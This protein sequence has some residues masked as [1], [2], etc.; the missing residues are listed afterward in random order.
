MRSAEL[1]TA[2]FARFLA[3]ITF[4][5]RPERLRYLYQV[6]RALA[7]FLVARMDV[8]VV[9]NT[10]AQEEVATLERML[11]TFLPDST[12]RV[13]SF[14]LADP[15]E[16]PWCHKQVLR[17]HFLGRGRAYTHFLY[18]EDDILF[19]YRSFLYFLRYRHV[20]SRLGLV[21]SFVRVEYQEADHRFYATDLWYPVVLET[22]QVVEV[23]GC[24]FTDPAIPHLAMFLM[25]HALAEEHVRS[26]SFD[27][28]LSAT[29]RIDYG[30]IERSAMGNA[31]DNVPQ[32][33]GSRYVIPLD[34]ATRAPRVESWIYHLPNTY[35]NERATPL[36]TIP[37]DEVYR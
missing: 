12:T 27:P 37:I 35:A 3:C 36:A 9:T 4:L 5:Y 21:P 33:F 16:L 15:K 24:L 26:P 28:E 34:R 7:D 32:G 25:D 20:L 22:R 10:A 8:V 31:F 11:R 30:Y 1:E 13:Q 29:M 2:L 18:L 19:S 17:D 6:F 14:E 23:G